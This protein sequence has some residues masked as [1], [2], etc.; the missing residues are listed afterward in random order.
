MFLIWGFS[1]V[2][3]FILL[4]SFYMP[5]TF[6]WNTNLRHFLYTTSKLAL[7]LN[8]SNLPL[9]Q[10]EMYE[11]HNA[12]LVLTKQKL[13]HLRSTE[14]YRIFSKTLLQ[15]RIY[16]HAIILECVGSEILTAVDTKSSIL[17][18]TTPCSQLKVLPT[19]SDFWL[20][21]LF[22]P[23]DESS[24]FFQNDDWLPTGYMALHTSGQNSSD[25]TV[26]Q[27]Y[28]TCQFKQA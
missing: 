7:L 14:K 6:L 22:N 17:W 1:S 13:C 5:L 9:C 4:C 11:C 27:F 23:E 10:I 26:L 24:M 20:D 12:Q 28:N 21:L 15:L 16:I 8:T 3:I 19:S 25:W 2:C 18:D